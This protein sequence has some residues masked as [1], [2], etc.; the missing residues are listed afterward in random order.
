MLFVVSLKILY[1]SRN[2]TI[3]N[4]LAILPASVVVYISYTWISNFLPR[5]NMMDITLYAS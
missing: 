5:N 1:V 3:L 2:L 4:G